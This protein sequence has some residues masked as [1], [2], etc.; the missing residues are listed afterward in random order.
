MTS[1]FYSYPLE[2]KIP[3]SITR[4]SLE[5]SGDVAAFW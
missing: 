1:L 3:A 4:E 5:V 2:S